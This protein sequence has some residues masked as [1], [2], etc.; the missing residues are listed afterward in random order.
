MRISQEVSLEHFFFYSYVH[1]VRQDWDHWDRIPYA[2]HGDATEF[3]TDGLLE[4][5]GPDR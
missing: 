1:L 3:H 4:L 2:S 5:H